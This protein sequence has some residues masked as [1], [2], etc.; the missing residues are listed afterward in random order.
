MINKPLPIN[1]DAMEERYASFAGD[2]Y[3][4]LAEAADAHIEWIIVSDQNVKSI[5]EKSTLRNS[6]VNLLRAGAWKRRFRASV[7]SVRTVSP[8][9]L[10]S[11]A[12][13]AWDQI[14]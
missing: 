12:R 5:E 4:L 14:F 13:D 9:F 2:M 11:S 10:T 6:S 8:E 7:R 3:V 1:G